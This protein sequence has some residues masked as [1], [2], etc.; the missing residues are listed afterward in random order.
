[1]YLR[2][3]YFVEFSLCYPDLAVKFFLN[4]LEKQYKLICL[5]FSV[6]FT[7]SMYYYVFI[8]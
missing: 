1:M 2:S 3:D 4:R 8:F 6:L 7:N 5:N